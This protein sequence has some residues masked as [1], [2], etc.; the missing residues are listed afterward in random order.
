MGFRVKKYLLVDTMNLA[1]RAKYS[2]EKNSG[3]S[4]GLTFHLLFNMIL[5][6]GTLFDVDHVVFFLEGKSWRKTKCS[7]YKL[8][9][10]LKHSKK[11]EKEQED[12]AAF[13][14][15][16]NELMMFFDLKT[17]CSVLRHPQLEADDLIAQWVEFHQ[18]DINIIMS[19][20]TDF[21]QLLKNNNVL[22]YNSMRGIILSQDRIVDEEG[23]TLE[24]QVD[25]NG[26]IKIKD[27][28]SAFIPDDD[29]YEWSLF[30]KLIRGDVSDNVFSAYP[31]ARVK[32]NKNK[33]GIREAFD[34]R[35]NMGYAWNNF[36]NTKWLDHSG[37]N[38]AVMEAFVKNQTLIDLTKQPE[39]YKKAAIEVI[40]ALQPKCVSNIGFNFVKFCSEW[41]LVRLSEFPDKVCSILNLKY[42]GSHK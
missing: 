12:D 32:S 8:N 39:E 33:V 6:S 1:H 35:K 36:M 17:N 3:D 37:N 22:I 31:G 38:I 2:A 25:N 29:W 16:F 23:N 19:C 14:E 42:E 34:D 24:F 26:K 40:S 27:T 11:T 5:K 30:L 28:N 7:L 9:R 4:I 21:V 13:M 15:A 41:D 18:K 10:E 20:D